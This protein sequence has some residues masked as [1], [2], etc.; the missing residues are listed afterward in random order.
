MKYLRLVNYGQGVEI[1]CL[2]AARCTD[3]HAQMRPALLVVAGREHSDQ[4][5]LVFFDKSSERAASKPHDA[6]CCEGIQVVLV[7][8]FSF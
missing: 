5:D 1:I 6:L 7:F 8:F 3:V 2:C 4:R